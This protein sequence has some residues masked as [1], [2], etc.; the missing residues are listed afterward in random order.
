MF[1]R[2]T[3]RLPEVKKAKKKVQ[4]HP[5]L[6]NSIAFYTEKD[7]KSKNV[8]G[9]KVYILAK[10]VNIERK[11]EIKAKKIWPEKGLFLVRPNT[12]S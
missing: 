10:D 7:F 4:K 8:R 11:L 9:K 1:F 6:T 5:N 2:T 3:W 12:G